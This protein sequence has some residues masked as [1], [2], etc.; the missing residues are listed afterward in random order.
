MLAA[1]A[2]CT[3]GSLLAFES[4]RTGRRQVYVRRFPDGADLQVSVED[5]LNPAWSAVGSELIYRSLRSSRFHAATIRA[6]PEA[7]VVER[8]VLFSTAR[9]WLGLV[10]ASFDVAADG[11]FLMVRHRD[12]ADPPD[13]LHAILNFGERLNALAPASGS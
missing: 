13:R 10:K 12:P 6:D 4:D 9:F 1:W 2:R 3:D 11:R 5:G 8:D 7:L